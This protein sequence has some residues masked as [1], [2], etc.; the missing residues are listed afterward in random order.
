MDLKFLEKAREAIHLIGYWK[1]QA[2][3]LDNLRDVFLII[4][5]DTGA[6]FMIDDS[7]AREVKSFI[8]GCVES[9]IKE[10]EDILKTL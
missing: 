5:D 2:D 10:Q 9:K 1:E 3:I 7:F 6:E 8:R 4:K